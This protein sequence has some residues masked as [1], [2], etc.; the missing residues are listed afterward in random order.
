MGQC[1]LRTLVQGGG[2]GDFPYLDIPK[3]EG[4]GG[5]GRGEGRGEGGRGVGGLLSWEDLTNI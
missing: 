4:G 3:G 5:E 2:R 1:K